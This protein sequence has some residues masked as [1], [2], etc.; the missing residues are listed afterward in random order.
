MERRGGGR[1]KKNRKQKK[2]LKTENSQNKNKNEN[3]KN[4]GLLVSWRTHLGG[5]VSVR[6]VERAHPGL[7]VRGRVAEEGRDLKEKN[8][9]KKIEKLK[10]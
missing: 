10:K 7:R 9:R 8:M 4:E 3:T 5:G 6:R 2:E 1:R